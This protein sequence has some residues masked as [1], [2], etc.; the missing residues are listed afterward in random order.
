MKFETLT[1]AE[2]AAVLTHIPLNVL[3]IIALEMEPVVIAGG[4][5]RDTV[6][7]LPVKDVDI[8]CR[9]GDQAERL[10]KVLSP[11]VRR[12]TFAYSVL[13]Y[14]R[15]IQFVYYKGFTD[16]SDL[17]GQF[18]FRACCAG[19]LWDQPSARW[20]GLAVEGFR[21]DCLSKAL[22]FMAQAKDAGK[23]TALGRA[24]QLAKRGWDLPTDEAAA[25]VTHWQPTLDVVGARRA[26]RPHYGRV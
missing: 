24:L 3:Q 17:I 26:F 25:I 10:A 12:T 1:E 14:D 13:E 7:T 19:I 16:A 23:L 18:D 6:A 22:R 20:V 5:I 4:V 8:F 21:E 2:I 11:F 9:S 15:P